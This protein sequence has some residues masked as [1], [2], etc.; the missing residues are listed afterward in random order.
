MGQFRVEI[1]AAGGHGCQ[2]EVKDG[3]LVYG[4]RRQG[5]PDC[6]FFALVSE[7]ARRTG[8]QVEDARLTHWPGTSGQ[9]VDV[10]DTQR[11]GVPLA[12]IACPSRKRTG[13]F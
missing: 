6:E 1:T 11:A 7:F 4:C 8:A 12:Q 10:L 2:R 13:S 9:V 3:G 5:C